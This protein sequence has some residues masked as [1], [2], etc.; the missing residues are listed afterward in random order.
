MPGL[1]TKAAET[2]ITGYGKRERMN[3][4][5]LPNSTS[6]SENRRPPN[7][8]E[9]SCLYVDPYVPTQFNLIYM[10]SYLFFI[11]LALLCHLVITVIEVTT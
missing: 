11:H 10:L 2:G 5:A 7:G 1:T 3:P 8:I 4:L 6:I 9:N